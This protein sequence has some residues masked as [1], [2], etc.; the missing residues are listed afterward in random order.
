[1]LPFHA[2]YI[3]SVRNF[4]VMFTD[5]KYSENIHYMILESIME[6]IAMYGYTKPHPN[7]KKEMEM[8]GI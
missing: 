3:P 6:Q 8:E 7:S 5:G 2:K 1:M 4:S